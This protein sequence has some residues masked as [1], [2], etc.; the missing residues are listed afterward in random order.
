MFRLAAN[1]TIG[2]YLDDLIRKKYTSVRQFGKAYIEAAGTVANDEEMRKMSNRLSQIIKGAK[3]VQIYDLPL[4]TKL[5]E[6][7][8]EEILSAG[9][10]F[11]A[12]SNHLTNYAI[13]ASKDETVWQAYVRRE[14]QLI[15]NADEYGKTVIDYAFD[16]SNY[17]FL[18]FLMKNGY[19]WFVGPNE[20]DLFA[21]HFGAGT[22]IKMH[23]FPRN[24]NVLNAELK[25]CYELRS[26]LILLAVR[27]GDTQML[28]TLHAKAIQPLYEVCYSPLEPEDFNK[29]YD[30]EILRALGQAD[31]EILEYFSQAFEISLHGRS[32]RFLFPFMGELIV[33]LIKNNKDYAEWLLKDAIAHNQYAYEQVTEAFASTVRFERQVL[34]RGKEENA[35]ITKS[36][37]EHF[38]F[39]DN[40]GLVKYW[41]GMTG[42]KVITNL[43]RVNAAPDLPKLNRLIRELNEWYDKVKNITPRL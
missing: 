2:Q 13:A 42:D 41:D 34:S 16:F 29:Y 31:D 19:I 10:C 15:L 7:S 17:E 9:T 12:T 43:I 5:L 4:F 37:M 18:S 28:H 26:K 22:S 8:C 27:H 11:S 21:P 6:V 20:K 1:E 3:A 23:S 24:M 39:Y 14:D 40:C 30:K 32:Y 38:E 35:I 25:G 36:I 33:T